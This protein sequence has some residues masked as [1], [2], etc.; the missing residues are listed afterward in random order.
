MKCNF[1]YREDY[2]SLKQMDDGMLICDGE[3]N[4]ILYKF[5][6]RL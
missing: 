2:C 5:F 6:T 3:E 1:R 4:C